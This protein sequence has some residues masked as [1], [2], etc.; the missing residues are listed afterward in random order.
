MYIR[1]TRDLSTPEEAGI[2][3]LI[4]MTLYGRWDSKEKMYWVTYNGLDRYWIKPDECESACCAYC[5]EKAL[6]HENICYDCKMEREME[7]SA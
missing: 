3:H 4:G 5:D 6:D 2:G 1:I 7:E